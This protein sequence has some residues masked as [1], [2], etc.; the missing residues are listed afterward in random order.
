MI[1]IDIWFSTLTSDCIQQH[2]QS[3]DAQELAQAEKFANSLLQSRYVIAHGRLRNILAYYTKQ[4]PEQ[5]LFAKTA[6]GKPFLKPHSELSFNLSHTSDYMAVAVAQ[7]CQ[8]GIDIEQ[9]K[10]RNNLAALVKKCFSQQESNYW[11]Q[12]SSAE[13][14][15]QFYQFWTRKEA[16]V[17]AT[18]LGIS[19]GLK[20]CQIDINQP[21]LFY[22]VPSVCGLAKQW[23]NRDLELCTNLCAAVV[24][25]QAIAE[26]N[27]CYQLP[28]EPS[29]AFRNYSAT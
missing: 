1:N 11:Q 25:N 26:V 6:H 21:E 12:L 4:A 8:L 22:S 14:I 5:L 7:N 13:Q 15:Q 10:A 29:T 19:L 3:L 18:G 2:W 16:F 20:H 27:L 17:K 9:I 23:H 28:N 24:A